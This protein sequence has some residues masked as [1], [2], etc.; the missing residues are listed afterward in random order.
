M[1]AVRN[2]SF[3][4]RLAAIRR[5]DAVE[6]VLDPGQV[7]RFGGSRCR[8]MRLLSGELYASDVAPESAHLIPIELAHGGRNDRV[9]RAPENDHRGHRLLG[10][11]AAVDVN[12]T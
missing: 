1:D 5:R 11:N 9:F 8:V 10:R 6:P 7:E 2:V 3:R 4:C 12:W